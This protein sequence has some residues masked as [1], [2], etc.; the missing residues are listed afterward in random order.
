MD[1]QQEQLIRALVLQT[2]SKEDINHNGLFDAWPSTVKKLDAH[3]DSVFG[4]LDGIDEDGNGFVD[5]VIGYNFVDQA[6]L[7]YGTSQGRSA[8]PVDEHGHGTAVAGVMCA[9]KN[10][11]L[12]ISGIAPKCKLVALR[13]FDFSGNGEDDDIA[14]AIVYAAD[15]NVRILNLSFGDV[16]PS[17][18]QRDAI[19]YATSKGVLVFAS[20]GNAGNR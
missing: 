8:A 2:R 19:R 7:N 14:A 10:N 3:G 9:Q 17:M 16:Y 6:S 5:D 1:T 13:A 4:D 18:L 12:G 11:R 20:S 15:N